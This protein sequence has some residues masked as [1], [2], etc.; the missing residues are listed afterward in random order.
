MKTTQFANRSPA[1]AAVHISLAD[2]KKSFEVTKSS[3]ISYEEQP[4]WGKL[5]GTV[6]ASGEIVITG[7]YKTPIV[8]VG[9]HKEAFSIRFRGTVV[10]DTGTSI[11]L[12]G[13]CTRLP[14]VAI[15]ALLNP[16]EKS[17]KGLKV[18]KLI[19][20]KVSIAIG[21]TEKE[22]KISGQFY[23]CLY[24]PTNAVLTRVRF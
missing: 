21:A 17:T 5:F 1:A 2:L 15:H 22:G 18:G 8:Q 14:G 10:G 3:A 24:T 13:T 16:V 4:G 9:E 11:S 23:R 6:D 19:I 7:Y 20:G 12:L